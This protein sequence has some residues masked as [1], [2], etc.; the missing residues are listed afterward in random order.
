MSIV[1]CVDTATSSV[2]TGLVLLQVVVNGEDDSCLVKVGT[3]S[4]SI[5]IE[6]L[7]FVL[8]KGE[9]FRFFKNINT[10]ITTKPISSTPPTVNPITYSL[11]LLFLLCSPSL[12]P[13][14][15]GVVEI[16]IVDVC[17][18]VFV[19]ELVVYPLSVVKLCFLLVWLVIGGNVLV[20]T[21][22]DLDALGFVEVLRVADF[23]VVG[24]GIIDVVVDGLIEVD[25]LDVC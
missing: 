15:P 5:Y 17:R 7:S 6:L 19:V 3:D 25:F 1:E 2:N 20:G 14:T 24:V 12:V 10:A 16:A 23:I 21:E 8:R 4:S 11:F 13:M 22:V 9:D 18:Y